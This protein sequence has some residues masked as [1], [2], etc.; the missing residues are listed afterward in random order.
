M[1]KPVEIVPQADQLMG[2]MRSMG[3]SFESAI[4]DIIDNSISAQ[5]SFVQLYFP[6]DPLHLEVCILDDGFGM[7]AE[8]LCHAMRYGSTACE[9]ARTDS[10][11]G[12]FGLGL[13][14]ASFSQCR[15]LTVVSKKSD[16]S[17]SGFQWDYDYVL[18]HKK[19]HLLELTELELKMLPHVEELNNQVSG[20]LVIWENFDVVE[21]SNTGLFK[22]L[23]DYKADVSNYISLIFHRYL[24]GKGVNKVKM[25]V[26]NYD[27]QPLDPFLES[28][29]KTSR[30]RHFVLDQLDS[31]GIEQ[32]IEVQPFILPYQTDLSEQDRALLGGTESL[33]TK[34]GFYIYRNCRLII[35]GTWF[36]MP[37]N[38]LSKNARIQVDIPNTLDDIWN[39]DI[40]KQSATIPKR[41]QNQL[42]RAMLDVMDISKRQITHRGRVN[43]L[44]D[45]ID[46]IW[47]REEGRN[48]QYYYEINRNS[49]FLTYIRQKLDDQA[50]SYLEMVLEEIE[51][52]LPYAQIYIDASSHGVIEKENEQREQDVL[53]TAIMMIENYIKLGIKDKES[54]IEEMMSSEPFCRMPELMTKLKKYFEI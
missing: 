37:R 48:K 14:T 8:E 1:A 6:M 38:E 34:Q 13:K 30:R 27:V 4:A 31:N 40:K 19:W 23:S 47:N 29:P 35:W 5:C 26:N 53:N 10:D 49:K 12:R 22:A 11:L 21:K 54:L 43:K 52:N 25:R 24:S 50:Q 18:K 46:Y 15:K 9:N 39:I 42:I 20:T 44:N 51:H 32:H 36:G 7:D 16:K 2:S 17:I 33:R 3:Y 45:D 41:L 28:N